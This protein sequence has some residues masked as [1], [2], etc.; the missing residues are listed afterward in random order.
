MTIIWS[1]HNSLIFLPKSRRSNTTYFATLVLHHNTLSRLG[2]HECPQ[3]DLGI[4]AEF[5]WLSGTS[6]SPFVAMSEFIVLDCSWAEE[7]LEEIICISMAER[8]FGHHCLSSEGNLQESGLCAWYHFSLSRWHIPYL[9]K[10]FTVL[11]CD[12]SVCLFVSS[13]RLNSW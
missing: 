12:W 4:P 10:A 9:Y 3:C 5:N 2:W 11:Y 1:F 8:I 6:C 7:R 13:L